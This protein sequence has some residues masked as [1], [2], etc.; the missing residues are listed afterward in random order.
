[1]I[2]NKL[3]WKWLV[4]LLLYG[5]VLKAETEL[6][7]IP[8]N[9]AEQQYI[10]SIIGKITFINEVMYLYD[11]NN[12]LLGS[13][14]IDQVAKIIV[15]ENSDTAIEAVGS[16]VHIYADPTQQQLVVEGCWGNQTL[17]VFDNVGRI[18]LVENAQDSTM[19]IDVSCLPNG[20]YLL[21]F[22]AQ[23]VKFIKQ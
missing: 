6:T 4:P 17:R 21:Q 5:A 7:I 9:G 23:V 2:K 14:P 8:L 15:S 19:R 1:M 11:C 18:V 3:K 22:G 20:T 16:Y 13:T 10:I 12:T